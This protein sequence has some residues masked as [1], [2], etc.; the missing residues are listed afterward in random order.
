MHIDFDVWMDLSF[1]SK[2]QD[3]D[4]IADANVDVV[5][6]QAKLYFR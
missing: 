6:V 2:S 3:S 4:S 1:V 5:E